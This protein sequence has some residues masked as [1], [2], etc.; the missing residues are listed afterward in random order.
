M[1]ETRATTWLSARGTALGRLGLGRL[2]CRAQPLDPRGNGNGNGR[3]G[4]N[5]GT[6]PV[7]CVCRC[8]V[9]EG[10]GSLVISPRGRCRKPI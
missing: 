6:P 1:S 10:R 7:T 9:P 3:I 5:I 4:Y 2:C 8:S